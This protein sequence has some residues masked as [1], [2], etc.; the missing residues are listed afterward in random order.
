MYVNRLSESED[1]NT[2]YLSIYYGG[3]DYFGQQLIYGLGQS[4]LSEEYGAW[5]WSITNRHVKVQN[6]TVLMHASAQT[7]SALVLHVG[8]S[9]LVIVASVLLDLKEILMFKMDVQV[10][11]L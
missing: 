7:A 10:H 5:S 4:G 11:I 2:N 3:S 6:K 9:M 8:Q 1:A